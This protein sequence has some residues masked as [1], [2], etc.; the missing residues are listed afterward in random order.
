MNTA[1]ESFNPLYL[2]SLP[3]Q[4]HHLF[5]SFLPISRSSP[6]VSVLFSPRFISSSFLMIFLDAEVKKTEIVASKANHLP[7]QETWKSYDTEDINLLFNIIYRAIF[8]E[9]IFSSSSCKRIS[10]LSSLL[11][12][13]LQTHHALL[14]LYA[15]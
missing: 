2:H 7:N 5:W 1:G 13:L 4:T 10:V 9:D 6:G 12:P 8:N 11:S 3:C 15:P 14:N